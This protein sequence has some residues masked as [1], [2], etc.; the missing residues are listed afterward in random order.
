[1]MSE[2]NPPEVSERP[3]QEIVYTVS[4]RGKHPR[5]AILEFLV[6]EY[7]HLDLK[8]MESVF[9]FVGPCTLYG[10]RPYTQPELSQRDVKALYERGIGLRLP[11]SNHQV[12]REEYEKYRWFLEKYQRPRNS[13]ITTSDDLAHWIRQDFPGYEIEASVI[14]EIDTHEKIDRVLEIYDTVVL[15]MRLNQDPD[16]LERIGQKHRVTLFANGGCALNCPAKVCYPSF[17]KANKFGGAK[18]ACSFSHKPRELYGMIDF[19]LERFK[20]MGFSRF[21]LLRSRRHGLTGF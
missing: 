17:S 21:K 19:D 7:P 15:P 9:G 6:Q 3:R 14:K 5:T 16:F 2:P 8:R 10:G 18:T 11:L 1:M 13:V 4:A 20:A 12:S